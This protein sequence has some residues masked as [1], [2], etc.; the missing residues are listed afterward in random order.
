ME[1]KKVQIGSVVQPLQLKDYHVQAILN[2][3][4]SHNLN[5]MD[6][7]RLFLCSSDEAGRA[8]GG[9]AAANAA[10]VRQVAFRLFYARRRN[11]LLAV[12]DLVRMYDRPDFF[13]EGMVLIVDE[14]L[15]EL[16]RQGFVKNMVRLVRDLALRT[17]TSADC[18]EHQEAEL[19]CV[20]AHSSA[21]IGRAQTVVRFASTF[22]AFARVPTPMFLLLLP[23]V[24]VP[25]PQRRHPDP[26]RPFQQTQLRCG[27]VRRSRQTHP[28]V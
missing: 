10:S 16:L 27:R 5:E 3:S 17:V 12:L 25:V 26:V 18:Y 19:R 7:V 1:S 20:R 8:S 15:Q 13:P 28:Y 6:V 22:V 21:L 23:I 2:F 9:A 11:L 4:D 24:C 14:F